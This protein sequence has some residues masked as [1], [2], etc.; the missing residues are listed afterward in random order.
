M[1]MN[2]RLISEKITRAS[3]GLE[4]NDDAG[5]NSVSN[6][7]LQEPRVALFMTTH[8]SD[9]HVA[10]LERCWP[11][12]LHEYPVLRSVDLLMYTTRLPSDE[13][14]SLLPF[15]SV[16]PYFFNNSGTQESARQAMIDGHR[17]GWFKPYEWV[18]RVNPDVLFRGDATDW[19]WDQFQNEST[20]VIVNPYQIRVCSDFSAFRPWAITDD[21]L[22]ASAHIYNTEAHVRS[23]CRNITRQGRTVF[24]KDLGMNRPGARTGS[25][26]VWHD[27]ASFKE[28]PSRHGSPNNASQPSLIK[29]ESRQ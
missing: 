10:Y 23:L 8:M 18:I 26:H 29:S 27:H 2:R 14:L 11:H 13:I 1:V 4:S 3:V 5:S 28:C 22:K 12:M 7:P 24:V 15:H 20:M 6:E 19:L 21:A 25:A 9:L 16:I 17:E